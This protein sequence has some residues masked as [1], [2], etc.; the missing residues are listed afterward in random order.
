MAIKGGR[1]RN[2]LLDS[3][4][5]FR[6][7]SPSTVRSNWVTFSIE[8]N[9]LFGDSSSSNSVAAL[10]NK[11]FCKIINLLKWF[12]SFVYNCLNDRIQ[13]KFLL[14]VEWIWDS[15][16]NILQ[17]PRPLC[18]LCMPS[19]DYYK[20]RSKLRSNWV[21]LVRVGIG[22]DIKNSDLHHQA[23]VQPSPIVP[24]WYVLSWSPK[25]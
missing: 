14:N 18:F 5:R 24:F 25:I 1:G 17:L 22:G 20:A 3:N 21:L 6:P 10:K 8:V 2:S 19:L 9:Q 4:Q 16:Y 11:T 12:R 13:L 15:T 23:I 7:Y